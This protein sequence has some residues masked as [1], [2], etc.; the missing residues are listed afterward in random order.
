MATNNRMLNLNV[1]KMHRWTGSSK[2]M[3]AEQRRIRGQQ[4]KAARVR[5]ALAEKRP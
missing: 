4:I 5:A 2:V 1:N 3:R